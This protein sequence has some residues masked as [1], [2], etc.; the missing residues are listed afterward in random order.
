MARFRG[1]GCTVLLALTYAAACA[2]DSPSSGGV[3]APDARADAAPSGGS[4]SHDAGSDGGTSGQRYIAMLDDCD[5]RDPGWNPTGGCLLRRGNVTFAEFNAENYSPL[6]LSVV[7]H[8]AWRNEPSYLVV[9]TD[10]SVRVRNEGGR[11]H[12]F[13]KVARFGGGRVP[14]LSGGLTPAP[15]CATA[16]DVAPGESIRVSNLGPDNN[17]FQCCIHPWM[18]AIIKVKAK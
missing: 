12:T 8:Q 13:T 2:K 11:V 10:K 14:P 15:E 18:R 9:E 5:P 6:A 16:R 3:V 17:R 4:S 1:V 7:G